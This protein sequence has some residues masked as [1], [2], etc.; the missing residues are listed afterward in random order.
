MSISEN[1]LDRKAFPGLSCHIILTYKTRKSILFTSDI[2][3]TIPAY[4][5]MSLH[6]EVHIYRKYHK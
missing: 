1:L 3:N 5:V 4:K 6:K 2:A